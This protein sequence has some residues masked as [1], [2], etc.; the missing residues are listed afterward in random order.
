MGSEGTT[1]SKDSPY[2]K[3]GIVTAEISAYL[4]DLWMA[5]W[6][7]IFTLNKSM[8]YVKFQKRDI[9]ISDMFLTSIGHEQRERGREAYN[10]ID[11]TL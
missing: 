10:V 4:N 8:I 3:V 5:V 6:L 11:H 2:F 7:L 9:E 1:H